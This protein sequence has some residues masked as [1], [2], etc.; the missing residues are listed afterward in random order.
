MR[1]ASTTLPPFMIKQV[2]SN[3]V[4][5]IVKQ[6]FAKGMFFQKVL[7]RQQCCCVRYLLFEKVDPQERTHGSIVVNSVFNAFLRQAGICAASS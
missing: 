1:V 5:T 2:L 3:M 4:R 7:E 6:L